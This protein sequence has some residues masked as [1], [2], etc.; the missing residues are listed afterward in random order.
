MN[1]DLKGI[2]FEKDS[3]GNNQY[4]RIEINR[5]AEELKPFFEKIGVSEKPKDWKDGISSQ[6][7]LEESKKILRK[8]FDERNPIP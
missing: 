2:S 3:E 5:Y 8:K 4:V 7:F 6:E 1:S